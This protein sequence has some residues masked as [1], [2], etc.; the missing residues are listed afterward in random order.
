MRKGFYPFPVFFSITIFLT[1]YLFIFLYIFSHFEERILS[2]SCLLFYHNFSIPNSFS[3]FLNLCLS[4]AIFLPS[5]S[6]S[7][8]LLKH[9]SCPRRFI[10]EQCGHEAP[11][12][13][14]LV[15]HIKVYFL[16]IYLFYLIN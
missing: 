11:N 7:L 14:A 15:Y 13:Q 9:R 5:V 10:C 1:I 16:N 2:F 4:R 6:L 8:C 3:L 12:P